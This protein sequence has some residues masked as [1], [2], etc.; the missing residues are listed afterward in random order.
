MTRR[1]RPL[2]VE[3]YSFVNIGICTQ[4]W[5]QYN[6][7]QHY[8]GKT[9]RHLAT[10]VREHGQASSAIDEH[11]NNCSACKHDYSIDSF[12]VID[13]GNCDMSVSIKAT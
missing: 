1:K 8:L 12:R 7:I 2:K 10:R 13:G 9:K 3:N 6:T 5:Q 11:L 4:H